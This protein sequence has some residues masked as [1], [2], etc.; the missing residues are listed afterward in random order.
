MRQR[1]LLDPDRTKPKPAPHSRVKQIGLVLALA[2]TGLAGI[3]SLYPQGNA[4]DA[5][6]SGDRPN[7]AP[8]AL[9]QILA[10]AQVL[11]DAA[12]DRLPMVASANA[13][14]APTPDAERP[15]GG[16]IPAQSSAVSPAQSR[17][18]ENQEPTPSEQASGNG[19]EKSHSPKQKV[20]RH[21]SNREAGPFAPYPYRDFRAWAWNSQRPSPSPFFHF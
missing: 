3:H 11:P 7:A 15:T 2:L 1:F 5:G 6:R 8:Q 16:S 13:L 19:A 12:A 4:A 21:R 14:Q 10:D 9:A 20:A 17:I 18:A